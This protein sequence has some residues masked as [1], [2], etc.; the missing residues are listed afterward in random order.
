MCVCFQ[1]NLNLLSE[2]FDIT[3]PRL[4]YI[5]LYNA[6]LAPMYVL[7]CFTDI[8]VDADRIDG[9]ILQQP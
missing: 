4:V 2:I 8:L 7:S 9:L 3:L 6:F 5:S 1:Q